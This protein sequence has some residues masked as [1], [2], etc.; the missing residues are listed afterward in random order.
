[1]T[2]ISRKSIRNLYGLMRKNEVKRIDN[3]LQEWDVDNEIELRNKL[4]QEWDKCYCACCGGEISLITAK[5]RNDL[6]Y[7]EFCA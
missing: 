4:L 7:C 2:T 5:W 6:P 3:L 1:M